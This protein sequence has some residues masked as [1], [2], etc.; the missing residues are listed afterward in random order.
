MKQKLLLTTVNNIRTGI[1]SDVDQLDESLGQN[2]AYIWNFLPRCSNK[3]ST[4]PFVI[5]RVWDTNDSSSV[6]SKV[7]KIGKIVERDN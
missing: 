4:K 6:A 2:S 3:R 7:F 5:V 1:I